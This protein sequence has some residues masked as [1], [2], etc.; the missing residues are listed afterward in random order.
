MLIYRSFKNDENAK[1]V[2]FALA[3]E[4]FPTHDT[5]IQET[6]LTLHRV[7]DALNFLRGAGLVWGNNCHGLSEGGQR[8]FELLCNGD[9]PEPSEALC[10][11]CL[12]EIGE[13][14]LPDGYAVLAH[15]SGRRVRSRHD[16]QIGTELTVSRLRDA[17]MTLEGAQLIQSARGRSFRLSRTGRRLE[18]LLKSQIPNLHSPSSVLRPSS[19]ILH[20]ESRR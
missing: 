12:L 18:R 11:D 4:D 5:L 3:K 8:L 16:L 19:S 20:S 1:R 13:L 7:R 10:D 9:Q 15:L 6:G 14:L 17:L 2:F